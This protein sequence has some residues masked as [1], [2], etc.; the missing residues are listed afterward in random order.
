MKENRFRIVPPIQWRRSGC[1]EGGAV[2][3]APGTT[4]VQPFIH[5]F[6]ECRDMVNILKYDISDK[7]KKHESKVTFKPNRWNSATNCSLAGQPQIQLVYNG[8][9]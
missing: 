9:S 2:G 3:G 5:W 6:W 1:T 8:A 7:Q 4:F